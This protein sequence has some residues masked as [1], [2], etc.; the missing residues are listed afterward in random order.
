MAHSAKPAKNTGKRVAEVFKTTVTDLS[1]RM[2]EAGHEFAV[3]IE[4]EFRS[5]ALDSRGFPLFS[6]STTQSQLNIKL[7]SRITP[8]KKEEAKDSHLE[9]APL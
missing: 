9:K 8:T 7:A 1:A 2:S 4:I 5:V 3:D 6:K